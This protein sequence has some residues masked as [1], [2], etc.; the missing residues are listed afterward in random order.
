VGFLSELLYYSRLLQAECRKTTEM[1]RT[2]HDSDIVVNSEP[3][4]VTQAALNRQIISSGAT[5]GSSKGQRINQEVI[6][7]PVLWSRR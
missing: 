5:A 3:F 7:Q 4:T 6:S 2:T 1:D